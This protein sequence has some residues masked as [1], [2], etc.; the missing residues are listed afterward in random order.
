ME[1]VEEKS[2]DE[3]TDEEYRASL[4]TGTEA[5]LEEAAEELA[6]EPDEELTPE[7]QG[8][9]IPEPQEEPTTELQASVE[10]QIEELKR[11]LEEKENRLK[12]SESRIGSLQRKVNAA[13]ELA[14]GLK[15]APT[16]EEI[17]AAG[18]S[19][20]E[21]ADFIESFPEFGDKVDNK[22]VETRDTLQKEIDALKEFAD[23]D[24]IQNLVNQIAETQRQEKQR[25]DLEMLEKA[26]PTFYE[27][28]KSDGFKE[29]F[30][31]QP[32]SI[33]AKVNSFNVVH[34]MEAME[35]FYNDTAEEPQTMTDKKQA[36]LEQNISPKPQGKVPRPKRDS[37]LTDDQYRQ[38][39]MAEYLRKN[40]T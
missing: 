25:Q 9:V 15:N 18:K 12:Q 38:K 14:E 26:F 5:P 36:R 30:D 31:G 4:M 37:D 29:W 24:A 11:T 23:N 8:E 34:S 2:L 40:R 32:K 17:L 10:R 6:V 22:I 3:L 13:V 7:P 35:K 16:E 20:K 28:A 39:K 27:D 33:Q 1:N 19:K 21:W